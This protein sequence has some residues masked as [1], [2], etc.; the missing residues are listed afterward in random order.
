MH[1]VDL[2]ACVILELPI[3]CLEQHMIDFLR[4]P[5]FTADQVVVVAAS[6]FIDELPIA[7]MRCQDHALLAEEA[8]RPVNGCLGDAWHFLLGLVEYFH[9]QHVLVGLVEDAQDRQPLR[10]EPESLGLKP[11]RKFVNH[12]IC[13]MVI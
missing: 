2:E 3:E 5:T 11:G 12:P 9:R 4:T 10:G 6:D 7:N 1:A 8:Q 13:L